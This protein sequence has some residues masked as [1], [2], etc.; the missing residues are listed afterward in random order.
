MPDSPLPRPLTSADHRL[1]AVLAELKAIRE[2]LTPKKT[3]AP[4]TGS[5]ETIEL[6]EPA[7]TPAKKSVP[8]RSKKATK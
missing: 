1:D 2:L 4:T 6:K 8:R 7:P 5:S 3:P